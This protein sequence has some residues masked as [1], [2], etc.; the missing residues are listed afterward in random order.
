MRHTG[1]AV[2]DGLTEAE[3]LLVEL[4]LGGRAER[5]FSA[6]T[7]AGARGAIAAGA[8]VAVC[9]AV[10]RRRRAAAAILWAAAALF[11]ATAGSA[12]AARVSTLVA[13]LRD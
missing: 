1:W 5:G 9:G 6:A 13:G 7:G 10:V 11:D 2:D 8:F 3:P 4:F 12:C